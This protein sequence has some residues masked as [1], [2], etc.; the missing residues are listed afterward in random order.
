MIRIK[1]KI[2]IICISTLSAI[3]WFI[4]C[5]TSAENAYWDITGVEWIWVYWTDKQ[6]EDSLMHTIRKAINW[7]IGLLSFICLCLVL[8]AWFLMLTSWWDSKKYDTWLTIMKNA[9]IWLTIM[10]L[11]WLIVS[12]IF[13]VINGSVETI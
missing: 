4:P 11:S 8:Y 5:I 9:A 2:A 1:R 3:F 6:Q 12:L 10:A 13:Y 7:V